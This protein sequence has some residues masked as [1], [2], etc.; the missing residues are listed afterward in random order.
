MSNLYTNSS[1]A[2]AWNQ[3]Y[4]QN[5]LLKSYNQKKESK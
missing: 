5:A 3:L 1:L 4:K 2:Q